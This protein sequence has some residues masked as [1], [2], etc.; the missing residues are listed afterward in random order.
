MLI[1][2]VLGYNIGC[3]QY[4]FRE[5]SKVLQEEIDL[6][7]RGEELD[8]QKQ[9]RHLTPYLYESP[10]DA[11]GRDKRG[12]GGV[13]DKTQCVSDNKTKAIAAPLSGD[14]AVQLRSKTRRDGKQD[15]RSQSLTLSCEFPTYSNRSRCDA[16][17]ENTRALR[18]R[19]RH[20]RLVERVL[21]KGL[22]MLQG[23][24]I[25]RW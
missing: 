12:T 1:P 19:H 21:R 15:A 8:R 10:S 3:E 13:N 4:Q 7:G 5:S 20:K 14:M 18:V 17:R 9:L 16:I 2:S 11:L 22:V 25:S 6:K 24:F 23:T